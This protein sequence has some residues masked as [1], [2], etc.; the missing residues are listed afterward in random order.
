MSYA[1]HFYVDRAMQQFNFPGTGDG[2]RIGQISSLV[3]PLAAY[4]AKKNGLALSVTVAE[5]LSG[6]DV[7]AAVKEFIAGDGAKW[8]KSTLETFEKVSAEDIKSYLTDKI[9]E[10]NARLGLKDMVVTIPSS[11]NDLCASTLDIQ[12]NDSVADL[13]AGF[14]SF[15]IH[16]AKNFPCKKLEGIEIDKRIRIFG[17]MLSYL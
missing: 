5:A 8:A 1:K 16:V 3:I 6:D 4:A 12:K 9:D 2:F 15:L 14:G 17:S 7:P 13:G 10:G 11:L